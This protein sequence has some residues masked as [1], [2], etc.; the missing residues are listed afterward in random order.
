MIA[1]AIVEIGDEHVEGDQPIE[2]M[3]VR[4]SLHAML[5]KGVDNFRIAAALAPLAPIIAI[6][7]RKGMRIAPARSKRRDSM[8]ALSAT[9]ISS[10]CG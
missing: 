5:R 4:F 7:D 9:S 1:Q 8:T 6:A 3:G 10:C 2:R